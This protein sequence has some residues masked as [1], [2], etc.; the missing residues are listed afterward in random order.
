MTTANKSVVTKDGR[1]GVLGCENAVYRTVM[2]DTGLYTLVQTHR[3]Y[4]SE[5]EPYCSPWSLGD[6]DVLT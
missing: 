5:S 4:D 2:V 6:Y 3:T 1:R